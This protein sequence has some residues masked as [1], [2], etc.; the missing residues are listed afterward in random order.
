MENSLGGE[1]SERFGVFFRVL[2]GFFPIFFF[3]VKGENYDICIS[4][5]VALQFIVFAFC[6]DLPRGYKMN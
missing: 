1:R 5:W 6:V 2:V 4:A 3:F